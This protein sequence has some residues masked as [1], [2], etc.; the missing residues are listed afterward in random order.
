VDGTQN[1]WVVKPSYSSRGLGI[2]CTN[3]FK[4]I[5]A[6]GRKNQSKVVQKY[7]EAPFL[8]NQRKFDLRQWVLVASWEPLDVFVFDA[9]YL[10]LCSRDFSLNDLHDVYKHLSNYSIQ[11][12]NEN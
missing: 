4:D 11:R 2:F 9:A 8:I 7:V 12:T 1:V 3:K 6:E 10:R 5:V